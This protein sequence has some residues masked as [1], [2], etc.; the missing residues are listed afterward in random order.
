MHNTSRESSCVPISNATTDV[1]CNI[2]QIP[3]QTLWAPERVFPRAETYDSSS[4]FHAKRYDQGR[5]LLTTSVSLND[6]AGS[7]MELLNTINCIGRV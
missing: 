3:I 7:T 6:E 2:K 5:K 1:Y 4:A